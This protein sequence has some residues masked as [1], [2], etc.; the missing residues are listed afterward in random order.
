MTAAASIRRRTSAFSRSIPLAFA[1]SSLYHLHSIP[2]THCY[3]S[4]HPSLAKRGRPSRDVASWAQ[5]SSSLSSTTSAARF[6]EEDAI[7]LLSSSSSSSSSR[8]DQRIKSTTFSPAARWHRDRRRQMLQKYGDT[9]L[10]LERD[11]S[12][13][14]LALS[15]LFISNASLFALSVLSGRL[16]PIQVA[17]LA[18]FPGSIFSLWTL[19]ILHDDLHGSLLNKERKDFFGIK[20]N[21]LQESLL[22]WGSM[23]SAFGYYLYLK[24]GH[25]THHKSLGDARAASLGQLF[26]SDQRDFEDGDV[27]FVAHR[28]KLKGDVGPTFKVGQKSFTLSISKMGFNS[29]KEGRPIR[30]AVAFSAS[31]MYERFMLMINDLIVAITGKNYFFPN[32]PK[33]FHDECARYCRCA[34]VVRGLLWKLGG[35]KSILF[36]FLSE[37]LWSI[38]PHP[39]CAMFVTNHGSDTDYE[40]G[41]CIPSSS[42][43]AGRWYSLLTLGTNYHLEHHDFPTIPLHKLGMIRKVAPEFYRADTNDNVYRIMRKAFATPEFYACMDASVI[44]KPWTTNK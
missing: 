28:M 41:N 13:H 19:Q 27:L 16:H 26:E 10:P 21:D 42:T 32:K 39:A 37:T 25:L 15:L 33:Q 31:F 35:W 17:L 29:W 23:P 22:F 18:L 40:T 7:P 38:P 4:Y 44:S 8:A 1:L 20:R 3:N 12:S 2:S 43:Y 9:I 6:V 36:L 34:I 14:A 30:N 5:R 24:Y 11:S